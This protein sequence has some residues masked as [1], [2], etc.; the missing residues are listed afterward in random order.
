MLGKVG[1]A[2]HFTDVNDG[3]G[4]ASHDGLGALANLPPL[5]HPAAD[6]EEDRPLVDGDQDHG[7][8]G[9]NSAD[10]IAEKQQDDP[11]GHVPVAKGGP[12]PPA[13]APEAPADP[14]QAF[15]ND[16]VA[17]KSVGLDPG[18]G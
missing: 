5:L 10:E 2:F 16:G 12:P 11:L 15:P 1:K 9:K 13:Q 4:G 7:E 17:E 14:T 8:T 6:T 18:G 3:F